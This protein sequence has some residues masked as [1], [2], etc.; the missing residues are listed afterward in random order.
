MTARVAKSRDSGI[1]RPITMWLMCCLARSELP[2]SDQERAVV[3]CL[4]FLPGSRKV[5]LN[6]GLSVWSSSTEPAARHGLPVL[7]EGRHIRGNLVE[8]V[9]RTIEEKIKSRWLLPYEN[10]FIFSHKYKHNVYTLCTFQTIQDS[11]KGR[12][13]PWNPMAW[14]NHC[15]HCRQLFL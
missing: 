11:T 5:L 15:S 3:S 13:T 10:S 8:Y 2:C 4:A 12:K 14:D 6:K 9:L 1:P 7:E